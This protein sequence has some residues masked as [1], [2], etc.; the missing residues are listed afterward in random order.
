MA[1]QQG[2][3]GTNE[4][5]LWG[6]RFAGGPSPELQRLSKSTHFDWQLAPYDLAGSRAHARALAAAGYLESGELDRML[7]GID[8]LEARVLSGELV[9]AES[10]EDVHGAL[11]AALIAEVGPELGGKLR[12]GRSR[13]DQ[14]AT[15]VRLYLK[16][17][18]ATIG[19]R[20]RRTPGAAG[21]L[22]G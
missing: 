2:A 3:H 12:A 22:A 6:A 10:D 17:H 20:A 5:S 16:D 15:L 11:E 7:T 1:D 18:A 9:A 13:N 21:C 14:I 19:R 8:A 4:G